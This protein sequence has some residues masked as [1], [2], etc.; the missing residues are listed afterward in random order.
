MGS[1]KTA[2]GKRL[3]KQLGY[4]FQDT[5]KNIETSQGISISEMFTRFGEAFFRLREQEILHA[6]VQHH[7]AVIS[8]GGGTPCFFDNIAW[9]RDHGIVVYLKVPEKELFRR[10][11]N[12]SGKRP[13]LAGLNEEQLLEYIRTKTAE[14]QPFYDQA[15]Q[16]IDP[17]AVSPAFVAEQL[18][19]RKN[20]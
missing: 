18:Q 8:C 14:R 13:L 20:L 17:T 1:G 16:V 9:M 6:T 10:L 12:Q 7:D 5:D 2:F 4:S 11:Q 15:H 3:A 19:K